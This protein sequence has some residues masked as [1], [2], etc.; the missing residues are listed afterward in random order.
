M[1]ALV[2]VSGL[3]QHFPLP[4]GP[5]DRLLDRR[6][7]VYA[8]DG[9][10]LAINRGEAVGLIGESGS[11]KS[12]FGRTLLQLYPPTAGTIAFE[13]KDVTGARG[14]QL[15]ELRR[16]LQMVFQ[17]PRGAVNRRK[18]VAQIIVEPLEVHR[19][20]DAGSRAARVRELLDLVGLSSAY[21]ARYP[22]EVSGGQLQRVGIAR[23]LALQPD[24]IVADEPT[25]SLDVSVRAQVINLLA[26]LKQQLGLTLLFISHDLSI[27]SY[28]SERVAVMYLGKVVELGPRRQVERQ[29]LHPYARALLGAVPSP[30]PRRRRQLSPPLGEIPSAID[31]PSGCH[32]H[33]RCPLAMPI[34]AVEYPALREKVPGR[35]A[36]CHAVVARPDGTPTLHPDAGSAAIV[37]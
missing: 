5:I 19:V 13:G 36:A 34:C 26:D 10:D 15:R 35:A 4:A 18:T 28:L 32:Y 3:K 2:S 27:V 23:A 12:T 21:G 24:F 30:D 29:P 6:R 25:A 16:R 9:V 22:H 37:S 11:G 33:P 7:V 17:N 31:R 20:G 8:L 1:S 14:E